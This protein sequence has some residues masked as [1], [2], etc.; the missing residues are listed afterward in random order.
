[1]PS[2]IP[3][4]TRLPMMD[5]YETILSALSRTHGQMPE[6]EILVAAL[7]DSGDWTESGALEVVRLANDYGVFML[8]NALA[9][10]IAMG[11]EDGDR[12]F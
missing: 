4:N 12:G 9:L 3:P 8:R 5:E 7:R 1:M 11:K 10:A 2:A 6:S